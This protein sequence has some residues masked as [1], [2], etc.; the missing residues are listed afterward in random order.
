[1]DDLGGITI[2]TSLRSEL[3]AS[4]FRRLGPGLRPAT[5][6]GVKPDF[7]KAHDSSPPGQ[8]KYSRIA[9][10]ELNTRLRRV[11]RR[12]KA[13][14]DARVW[15]LDGDDGAELARSK[16]WL[17]SDGHRRKPKLEREEAFRVF[18]TAFKSDVVESDA[19]LYRLGLL[20]DNEQ[21]RGSGFT[22]D[23][24]THAEPIYDVRPAKRAKKG[25][26]STRLST[27][28]RDDS[29]TPHLDLSLGHDFDLA[30]Q[31]LA[32]DFAQPPKL[33]PNEPEQSAVYTGPGAPLHVIYETNEDSEPVTESERWAGYVANAGSDCALSE[34][35]CD[36]WDWDMIPLL[37][38]ATASI[39]EV[40]TTSETERDAR[41]EDWIMLG[42]T[43][44]KSARGIPERPWISTTP[45]RRTRCADRSFISHPKPRC[46]ENG[47]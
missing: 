19:E 36:C 26:R 14:Q 33:F 46:E 9:Q 2:D 24:I 45:P 4:K 21:E 5:A 43:R 12:S 30:P 8:W 35:D 25:R 23:S 20:Y 38:R 3:A 47:K 11:N 39:D 41:T 31:I 13:C 32:L 10:G 7:D 27:G 34:S 22:L 44:S 18:E 42:E 17:P 29:I 40:S 6:Q 16:A 37:D 1:M 15:I 28:S